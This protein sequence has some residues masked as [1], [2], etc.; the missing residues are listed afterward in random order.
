MRGRGG[1]ELVGM[2][3]DSREC[4]DALF[5]WGQRLPSL[6]WSGRLVVSF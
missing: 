3:E 1:I 4:G 6:G 2:G 5:G